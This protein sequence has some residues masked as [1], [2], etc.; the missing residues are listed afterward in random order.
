M[1]KLLY[2][3]IAITIYSTSIAITLKKQHSTK[4]RKSF[5]SSRKIEKVDQRELS[6][7]SI[8]SLIINNNNGPITIR[9]G[10]KNS[11]FLKT[12]KRAKKQEYLDNLKVAIN[13]NKEDELTIETKEIN[14]KIAGTIEYEL[15]VPA[16]LNI[17][18]NITGSGD[19]FIKGVDGAI[20]V[21]TN[22]NIVIINSKQPVFLETRKKGSILAMNSLGPIT[23]ISQQGTITGKNIAHSFNAHSKTGKVIIACKTI[24]VAS[25]VNLETTSGNIMLALPL[26]TNAEIIG[27]TNYGTITSD[28]YI[29]LKP[30]TTKLNSCAWSRFK[31]EVDGTI[32]S[33]QATI[34]L[35]SMKG[36][37]KITEI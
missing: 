16:S 12:T 32:G 21:I 19:A 25:A 17:T 7:H 11:F 3:I 8:T 1:N 9:A 4:K 37:L 33:G 5:F 26:T 15:I 18:L 23:A 14:K 10:L 34:A 2:I 29:M 22:D 20:N 35:R 31:K 24:P 30:Y 13:T 28:H 27:Q 6:A 36:N